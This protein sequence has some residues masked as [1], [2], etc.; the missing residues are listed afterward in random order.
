[1]QHIKNGIKCAVRTPVK[2]ALFTL[3]LAVTA[4]MLSASLTVFTAVSGYL[5]DC[6][7]YFHT[8]A[9][10]EYVGGDYPDERVFD[11][12]FGD[13]LAASRAD[14]GKLV[15]SDF[16]LSFEPSK[17]YLA[18]SPSV[19]IKDDS[20]YDPFAAVLKLN[21]ISY[22]D[23]IGLWTATVSECL[24]S[25]NDLA[26]KIVSVSTGGRPEG[27][28]YA[29]GSFKKGS[30]FTQTFFPKSVSFEDG[31]ETVALPAFAPAEGSE[32]AAKY[33]RYAKLLSIQNDS[34]RAFYTA[35]A[36]DHY[37]FHVQAV[38]LISGRFF[39][40]EE[41]G[42]RAHSVIISDRL[43][44]LTGL[45]AGDRI[46][47]TVYGSNGDVF[48]TQHDFVS[49]SGDYEIVGI[50]A[51]G[52]S[53][54]WQVFLPDANAAGEG[55]APANGY[56]VGTFR[57]KNKAAAEFLDLARPLM[58]SGFRLSVGD[59]GYSAAAEPMNELLFL[60]YIFLAVSLLL[61][62]SALVLQSY[63]Y[64]SRQRGAALIMRDL[65]S[66]KRRVFVYFL[67][68][69]LLISGTAAL[70]GVFASRL[71]DGRITELLGRIASQFAEEDLSFSDSRL[72]AVRTLAFEPRIPLAV[73][74]LSALSLAAGS[75]LST[76][77]FTA[78]V[79][80]DPLAKKAKKRVPKKR[81]GRTSRLSGF[82]KY[83]LL[84]ARRS[85]GRSLAVILLLTSAGLF[86]GRAAYSVK[87]CEDQ[88]EAY[89]DNARI[90]GF[91]TNST[92]SMLDGLFVRG[93]A[94]ARLIE[95]GEIDEF[96]VTNDL[97]SLEPLGVTV[98]K[99]GTEQFV[100][101]DLPENGLQLDSI[102]RST[103]LCARWKACTSLEDS[104]MFHFT[105][106]RNIE[107]LEGFDDRIFLGSSNACAMPFSMM[108]EYGI[109]LGDVVR[110]R[111]VSLI[112]SSSYP[113][114]DGRLFCYVN[115]LKVVAGY[116]SLG[117]ADAV[118][119]P[120]GYT[121][122]ETTVN[123]DACRI[124]RE[125]G[126]VV[127]YTF[128]ES[129][130]GFRF[131]PLLEEFP[132]PRF[133][134]E[135]SMDEVSGYVKNDRNVFLNGNVDIGGNFK[136]FTFASN[137]ASRLRELRAALGD[138]F[139]PVRSSDRSKGF[140]VIE[141]EVFLSAVRS[142]KRQAQYVT[143]FNRALFVL[144]GIT[145][146]VLAWLITLSRRKEI[147]VMRA[148]GTPPIR[149]LVNFLFEQTLLVLAGACLVIAVSYL[150]GAPVSTLQLCL[151]AGF[152]LLWRLSA[153]VCLLV[154]LTK[155]SY[156]ALTEPE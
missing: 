58:D 74:V 6:D 79:L 84:S 48:D 73:Y 126:Q 103:E 125:F 33:E 25:R 31:S 14:I 27:T 49:D 155:R 116:A 51:E 135:P 42:S 111:Y 45:G 4:A 69:A 36:E 2:T 133:F 119:S 15:S 60:S 19:R 156:A 87:G 71:L 96:A 85:L 107:W 144:A 115:E 152:L 136:S 146:S 67:S 23:Q 89:R 35:S 129:R 147:A 112:K 78:F 100:T 62:F 81:A 118:Y 70:F 16:T 153:L 61:V 30:A 17:T 98:K 50:F 140:A 9:K 8:I 105:A 32:L 64:V 154:S 12:A 88:L 130:Q 46:P 120:I 82:F 97:G 39:T 28:C 141:D 68:S 37:L 123:F 93:T 40:D 139:T 57:I 20:V 54:P 149:I 151:T 104:P 95:S 7:S 150:S 106:V 137:D 110:V 75:V 53:D 65:G 38:S 5:D 72:A 101:Y 122:P 47:L 10:L 59:Q 77:A 21:F 99:D 117:N 55:F 108:E 86:F 138:G 91:A 113:F 142:M 124:L 63:L 41:Y 128:E 109:E 76:A 22:D 18:Y 148:L 1:M 92:G 29:V 134:R 94:V 11:P 145:G 83:G 26:G 132:V 52:E 114:A 3:L 24:Y 131:D 90:T 127:G 44:R 13:S 43:S 56:S 102:C 143:A 66:P 80:K 121:L 34:C